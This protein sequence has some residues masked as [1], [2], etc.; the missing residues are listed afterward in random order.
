MMSTLTWCYKCTCPDYECKSVHGSMA[1][2][3]LQTLPTY[4]ELVGHKWMRRVSGLLPLLWSR[5]G[6][7]HC[8]PT[9][10]QP[11]PWCPPPL[12]FPTASFEYASLTLSVRRS[13]GVLVSSVSCSHVNLRKSRHSLFVFFTPLPKGQWE[14]FETFHPTHFY[15]HYRYL[16]YTDCCTIHAA[17]YFKK[18]SLKENLLY[19]W[20]QKACHIY[21]LNVLMKI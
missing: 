8:S 6:N 1:Q 18:K 7:M 15:V 16:L 10:A 17:S 12:A 14:T 21:F 4:P 11:F 3:S 9:T 5:I 2:V 13:P 20:F 19:F